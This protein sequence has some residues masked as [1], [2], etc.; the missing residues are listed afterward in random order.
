MKTVELLKRHLK[1]GKV[2]WRANLQDWSNSIDRHLQLLVKDGTLEKLARGLYYVPKQTAFGKAPPEERGLISTFLKDN[3][4][5]IMSPT[6]YNVLGVGTTQ[7]YNT[8]RVYNRKRNGVFRLGG[9]K[10]NFVMKSYVPATMTREFLLVDLTNNLRHLAEDQQSLLDNI[11]SKV[12]KLNKRRL[13][14]LVSNFGT[15]GTKKFFAQIFD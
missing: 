5:L 9:R 15:A 3:R 4:F 13:K 1:P 12:K 7:L 6:D 14:R 2:F 10:F 11:K 8:H